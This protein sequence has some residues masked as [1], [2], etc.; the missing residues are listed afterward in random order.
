MAKSLRVDPSK[1]INKYMGCLLQLPSE[2]GMR[3][4]LVRCVDRKIRKEMCSVCKY[5]G[6]TVTSPQ[7]SEQA[8][9]VVRMK[10]I[11]KVRT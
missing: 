11:T 6:I 10:V 7:V 3:S 5:S 8:A 4:D 2:D 1:R 9:V